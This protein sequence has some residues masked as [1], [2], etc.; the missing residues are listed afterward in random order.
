MAAV[1]GWINVALMT[2]R[3]TRGTKRRV[4]PY[5]DLLVDWRDQYAK[6]GSTLDLTFTP[7]VTAEPHP[8]DEFID[9][10][11]RRMPNGWEGTG[12]DEQLT[13]LADRTFDALEQ[14]ASGVENPELFDE[15][16][17]EYAAMYGQA[18]A[19][20]RSREQRTDQRARRQARTRAREEFAAQQPAPAV[21]PLRR[22]VRKIRSLRG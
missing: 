10:G 7:A 21:S 14:L 20:M 5:A 15:L 9:G 19:I 16:S 8:I 18:E 11:L 1:A 17:A 13:G 6:I 12:I 3:I 2:E 4:V 22:V